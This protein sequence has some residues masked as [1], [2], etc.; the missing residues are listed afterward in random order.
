M[1]PMLHPS[2]LTLPR[3][4]PATSCIEYL[5][6]RVVKSSL[7]ARLG[8]KRAEEKQEAVKVISPAEADVVLD[9][10]VDEKVWSAVL[11]SEVEA[12]CVVLGDADQAGGV[13]QE[14]F[15]LQRVCLA[16]VAAM[17]ASLASKLSLSKHDEPMDLD[18][19]KCPSKGFVAPCF[20]LVK[21][22]NTTKA[23]LFNLFRNAVH[24]MW[25]LLTPVEVQARGD[26][27]LFTFTN[28]R[29]VTRVK[30]GGHWCFQHT[31]DA[32]VERL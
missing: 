8:D 14:G 18:D 32:L 19:L 22:L 6:G 2:S 31:Y 17:I 15:E 30:R 23:M 3:L 9:L 29:D 10:V 24:T 1:T 27:F 11:C 25:Q 28:E 4:P 26:R 20:Y 16:S 7:I 21:H 12:G 13:V 5:V